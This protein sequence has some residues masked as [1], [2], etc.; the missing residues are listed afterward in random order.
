M[1]FGYR[2]MLDGEIKVSGHRKRL[3]FFRFYGGFQNMAKL[4]CTPTEFGLLPILRSVND[5]LPNAS[6]PV[7]NFANNADEDRGFFE[8]K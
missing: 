5:S 4:R 8:Q 2:R 7:G 1:N 3:L 6:S